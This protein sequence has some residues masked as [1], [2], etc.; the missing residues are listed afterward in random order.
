RVS[1]SLMS[2]WVFSWPGEPGHRSPKPTTCAVYSK[3]F[4]ASNASCN[5]GAAARPPQANRIA[6]APIVRSRLPWVDERGAS[7]VGALCCR[8]AGG[9]DE[10]NARAV[11]APVGF[12]LTAWRAM[13]DYESASKA[14]AEPHSR[15]TSRRGRAQVGQLGVGPLTAAATLRVGGVEL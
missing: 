4:L 1:T 14:M 5:A 11:R 2:A 3:H 13:C 9:P 6:N 8:Q 15:R 10:W 7:M 12:A